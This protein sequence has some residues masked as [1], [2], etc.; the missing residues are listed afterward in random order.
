M[1]SLYYS[2]KDV[3]LFVEEMRLSCKDQ[4]QMISTIWKEERNLLDPM[5]YNNQKRFIIDVCYWQDYFY[6]KSVVDKELQSISMKTNYLINES[7]SEHQIEDLLNIYS[8]FK[9]LRIE[10]LYERKCNYV[11]RSLRGLLADYGYKRKPTEFVTK[12][13]ECMN[14]YHLKAYVKTD[15]VLDIRKIRLDDKITFIVTDKNE[16]VL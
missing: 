11:I 6:N 10:I 14:F 3:A 5:Y 4:F 15:E 16:I 7:Y 2:S 12:Y 9:Q 8:M 1:N 13:N